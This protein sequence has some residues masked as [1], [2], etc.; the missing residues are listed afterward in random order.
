MNLTAEHQLV[1]AADSGFDVSARGGEKPSC[2]SL[3]VTNHR[4][5]KAF[6]NLADMLHT[7]TFYFRT[8]FNVIKL[9]S[10]VFLKKRII[11]LLPYFVNGIKR[12]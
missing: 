3:L 5:L 6:V 9:H 1:E 11:S 8:G 4:H 12:L 7:I 2:I 10:S